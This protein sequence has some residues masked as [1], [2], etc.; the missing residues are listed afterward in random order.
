MRGHHSAV[1]R[2]YVGGGERGER[3]I[4]GVRKGRTERERGSDVTPKIGNLGRIMGGRNC[5]HSREKAAA[6]VVGGSGGRRLS[7]AAAAVPGKP[8][9]KTAL[10]NASRIFRLHEA[11]AEG[12][13]GLIDPN[14]GLSLL[15][16]PRDA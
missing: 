8:R 13:E 10:T 14:W 12:E 1:E 2:T 16:L 4:K 9:E 6:A 5:A 7:A 3:L 15:S 11:R